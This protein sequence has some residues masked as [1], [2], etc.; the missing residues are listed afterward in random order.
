LPRQ[1]APLDMMSAKKLHISSLF[2]TGGSS[3]VACKI[4]DL[5]RWS[6]DMIAVASDSNLGCGQGT[7]LPLNE[8]EMVTSGI[9]AW[10]SETRRNSP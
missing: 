8:P 1:L 7:I 4:G 6:P 3:T 2:E 5:Q 9:M 10:I